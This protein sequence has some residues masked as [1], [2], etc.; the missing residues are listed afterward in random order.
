MNAPQDRQ[1][2]PSQAIFMRRRQRRYDWRTF[3]TFRNIAVGV[4]ILCLLVVL[5]SV[6]SPRVA[7]MGAAMLVLV[8]FIS[9]EMSMRRRW[10]R[11]I[12]VEL[13]RVGRDFDRLVREVARNR[14]D[15]SDTRRMLA[16]AG[17]TARSYGR[18]QGDQFELE[19]GVEQRMIRAIAEQLV[20]MDGTAAPAGAAAPESADAVRLPVIDGLTAENATRIL[21]D[22]Q[23]LL[24]LR[25]AVEKDAVDLFAQPVVALP[26]RKA[27]FFEV[28]SRIRLGNEIYLPAERY[29]AVALRH[30]M[31]PVIDNLLLLR[32]LQ[33]V[34][35][36]GDDG[37]AGRAWFCNITSLTLNDAKFMGDLVEF[38]AAYRT[39][40]SRL[41]FEFSH[42]DLATMQPEGLAVLDGLSRL[43][44][45]FSVDQVRDLSFD[46]AYLQARHVRFI[47]VDVRQVIA[48][49]REEDGLQ[50]VQRLKADLDARGIDLIV[51]K[52]ETEQQLIEMLDVE[53]DYGQ[54]YLFG[55]PVHETPL[56]SET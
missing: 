15:L 47:K 29:M 2:D 32:V 18:G 21:S 30:N 33:F 44:C 5:G 34:R 43:G 26:Q 8:A 49:L 56:I 10:E 51:G 50:R 31:L 48:A 37:G 38:I 54:G 23:I 39:L 36:A 42:K 46:L 14:N 24:F 9:V 52:I 22:E 20:R 28:F 17:K 45:R 53:I 6:V 55:K 1:G 41:V 25:H 12:I 16:E 35:D 4:V 7:V 19:D 40:A 3:M 13:Q 27:R 11:D